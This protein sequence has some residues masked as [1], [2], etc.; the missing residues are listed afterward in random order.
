MIGHDFPYL[1]TRDINL[2]WLLKNMKL[3]I[4]QWADYQTEMNQ[5]FSDLETAF[6][7]L[8]DWIDSYF[9]N[10]DVQ[11]EINNK[12]DA[13]KTSGELGEIMQ[14]IISDETAAWLAAHITQPTTPAID[15]TLT[16]AGA[17]ADAKAA[18]DGIRTVAGAVNQGADDIYIVS[19]TYS[20]ADGVTPAVVNTRLRNAEPIYINDI[21]TIEAP[22][23]FDFWFY[24][25]D[26]DKNL[27]AQSSGWQTRIDIDL[28]PP[29]TYYV[30]M[31]I[32]RTATPSDN[33][34]SYAGYVQQ[35]LT[36]TRRSAID[37]AEFKSK[38]ELLHDALFTE[39]INELVLS[40]K[41]EG[42]V[43]ARNNDTSIV[44]N[45]NQ[46]CSIYDR[47]RIKADV[48]YYYRNLYGYFCKIVYDDD[49]YGYLK[50]D[51]YPYSVGNFTPEKDGYI[52]I[53][54]NNSATGIILF[55][56]S[57]YLYDAQ[58]DGWFIPDML[59]ALYVYPV[60]ITESEL[61][62]DANEITKSAIYRIQIFNNDVPD[63]LPPEVASGTWLLISLAFIAGNN[64]N[65]LHYLYNY[66]KQA[67]LFQRNAYNN[68]T[69]W[70]AWTPSISAKPTFY[71]GSSEEYTRLRDGI[72]EAVKFK[73]A[74]VIVRAGTYDIVDEFADEI[75]ASTAVN[76]GILLGNGVHVIFDPG[77]Y[78]VADYEG[79]DT[80]ILNN[81]SPFLAAPIAGG[82]T[83]ENLNIS[84][85]NTRYCVHDDLGNYDIISINKYINCRMI[86]DDRDNTIKSYPQCIGGGFGRHTYVSI[87]NCFF[88]SYGS[89]DYVN[90]LVSYHNSGSF[91]D[92]KSNVVVSNSY[93]Y[94]KGTYRT[95]HYGS[96]TAL[97]L[98]TINNC[99]LGAAPIVRHEING[100]TTPENT[101]IFEYLNEVRA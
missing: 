27:L 79:S 65:T 23:G 42:K 10:L 89:D 21:E 78:V 22:A 75:A 4:K 36:I 58:D 11:T 99:S 52:Y 20:G 30:N 45:T 19:G 31:G 12:L 73:D 72:A 64:R 56:E 57:E 7:T 17:A 39:T 26:V 100:A 47:V 50:D 5:Q 2:D 32:R 41:T 35:G 55:T 1:D 13:M 24:A 68:N 70:S 44:V 77:A 97:S 82:F 8:K 96:S 34:T 48:T 29:G 76:F 67:I 63:N 28:L 81:F 53:S 84:T 61:L 87:E 59:R 33:I 71:V 6:N 62:P 92:A 94:G 85:K 98:T 66:Q 40:E 60:I 37:Y 74:T 15:N 38:T 25:L 46:Y 54:V 90:P 95:T 9:E 14:P 43:Y 16:V 49:T 93:F 3:I 69:T 80:N 18:G 51:T 86:H 88:R 83:L 101:A 91:S